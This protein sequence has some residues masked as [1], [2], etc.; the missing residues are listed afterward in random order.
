M[1][2]EPIAY[3]FSGIQIISKSLAPMPETSPDSLGYSFSILLEMKVDEKLKMVSPVVY[4]KIFYGEIESRLELASFTVAYYFELPE[5]E[6]VM[7]KT[8]ENAYIIPNELDALMKPIAISTTR[9]IIYSEL[10]GTY[11]QSVLLPVV[12]MDK[13]DYGD[14]PGFR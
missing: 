3:R 9:G 12:I 1:A 2:D 14:P 6:K 10:R 11:L 5:F 7:V 8:D 13:F 4:I